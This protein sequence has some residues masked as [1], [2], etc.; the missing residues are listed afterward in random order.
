[1]PARPAVVIGAVLAALVVVAPTAS[2]QGSLSPAGSGATGG[3]VAEF[4]GSVSGSV[5]PRTGSLASAS[6]SVPV[7][8]VIGSANGSLANPGPLA[9]VE[10]D[11]DCRPTAE[12]PRPVVLVHGTYASG[13]QLGDS[14][15]GETLRAR[16]F[17]TVAPTLGAYAFAPHRGGLASVAEVSGPQL[18]RVIDEVLRETGAEQVDLVGFSQGAAVAG[19]VAEELRPGA[20]AAIATLAGYWGGDPSALIPG[21]IDAGSA[22][23]LAGLLNLNALADLLPGGAVARDWLGDGSP[24]VPGVRYTL[25]ASEYDPVMPPE[26]S[27]VDP[28]TFAGATAAGVE[29]E[30]ILLQDG[31]PADRSDH[32]VMFRSPRAADLVVRALDPSAQAPV[33]CVDAG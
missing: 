1:M 11:V 14:T 13:A 31:C 7:D 16:G 24:F 30:Q 5:A 15:L 17:C 29:V 8:Q 22:G 2:S 25:I 26:R 23:S 27:F 28:A 10:V 3:S 19:Y 9:E 20:V 12:R 6:A 32:D 4:G 18:A 21:G 33:R